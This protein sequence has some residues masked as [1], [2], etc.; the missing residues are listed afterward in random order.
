[1]AKFK[2]IIEEHISQHF[3]VE[4]ENAEQAQAIVEQKYYDGEFV[5]DNCNV[6]TTKLM[7]I[8]NEDNDPCVEWEEF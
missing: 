7:Y 3:E 8:A 4:A 1:M 5:V 6:P 2:V